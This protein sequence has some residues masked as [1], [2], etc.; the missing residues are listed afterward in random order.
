MLLLFFV[1][2]ISIRLFSIPHYSI[3]NGYVVVISIPK[4]C[5]QWPVV[6]PSP[7]K[8]HACLPFSTR[9]KQDSIKTI[10]VFSRSQLCK[11]TISMFEKSTN[12]TLIALALVVTAGKLDS[13]NWIPKEQKVVCC[14]KGHRNLILVLI[15]ML[16]MGWI[17]FVWDKLIEIT[18]CIGVWNNFSCMWTALMYW[19]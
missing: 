19:Q 8:I 14:L 12:R 18:N 11:F 7:T 10:C 2:I 16:L 13:S 15:E 3:S 9:T 5:F 17:G 1:L 6:V 4:F